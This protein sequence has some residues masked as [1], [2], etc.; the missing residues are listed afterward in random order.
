MRRSRNILRRVSLPKAE[1]V[2]PEQLEITYLLGQTGRNQPIT[3]LMR[4]ILRLRR[5]ASRS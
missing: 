5:T 2:N 4:F 1:P 3:K